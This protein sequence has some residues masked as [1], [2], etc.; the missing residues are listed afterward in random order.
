MLRRA[1][2]AAR[3]SAAHGCPVRCCHP[4]FGLFGGAT[5]VGRRNC[6]VGACRWGGAV[7]RLDAGWLLGAA[8]VISV[9]LLGAAALGRRASG[10]ACARR[11][12][13]FACWYDAGVAL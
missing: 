2:K 12:A 8:L 4:K 10:A 7:V 13:S 3:P 5:A 6:G 11:G 9:L 1:E